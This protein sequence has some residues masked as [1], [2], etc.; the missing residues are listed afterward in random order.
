[1]RLGVLVNGLAEA[2]SFALNNADHAP[3]T[4][5]GSHSRF[6]LGGVFA[7]AVAALADPG[8]F[9]DGTDLWNE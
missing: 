4:F 5:F 6:L 8:A 2:R 9:T 1:M 7:A 3:E